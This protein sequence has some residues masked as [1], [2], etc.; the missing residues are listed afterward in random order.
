MIITVTANP[1]MDKVIIL[2]HL[3]F[4]MTNRILREF[5]CIGGKG[6]HISINLSILGIKSIALGVVYGSTG[7]E[8][9]HQLEQHNDVDVDFLYE[10]EGESRINY[11][12]VDK[13]N[14]TILAQKGQRIEQGT[15]KYFVNKLESIVKQGDFVAISGDISNC[16][17][18]NFQSKL[19]DIVNQKGAKVFLDCSGDAL[20]EGVKKKPFLIKPNESELSYFC[21]RSLISEQDI[22]QG[23]MEMHSHGVLNIVVSRGDKG[24]I[25]ISNGVLYRVTVPD[26]ETKNTVGCGDAL[27]A[28]LLAGFQQG[29][30]FESNL[31]YSNAIATAKAMNEDTVGFDVSMLAELI[32]QVIVEKI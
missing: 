9:I 30:D 23:M 3:H 25:A 21:G 28:G 4:N 24:S 32:D 19:C 7:R 18:R 26:V 16:K 29:L 1:A 10:D 31:K 20:L 17:I 11:V 15:A 5:Y 12:L 8:I 22:I 6:T 27:V 13:S 2:N 14:S